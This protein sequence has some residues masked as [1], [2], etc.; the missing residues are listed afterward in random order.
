MSDDGDSPA[1]EGIQLLLFLSAVYLLVL[2]LI[3]NM[4]FT[5]AAAFGI[6]SLNLLM[7]V[8]VIELLFN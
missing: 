8:G 4:T 2:P 7:L 3:N 1:V 5:G 6:F